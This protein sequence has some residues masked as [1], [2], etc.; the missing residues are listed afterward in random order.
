MKEYTMPVIVIKRKALD[1]ANTNID[2]LAKDLGTTK[3][4]ITQQLT[5]FQ[6]KLDADLSTC[7]KEA[8]K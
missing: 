5:D 6:T 7:Y 2:Q 8:G 4:A 1:E 3:E